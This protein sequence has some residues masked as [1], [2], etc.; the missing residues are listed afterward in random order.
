M[1]NGHVAPSIGVLLVAIAAAGWGQTPPKD[2]PA[3]SSLR[4][5]ACDDAKRAAELD[6]AIK[7]ALSADRWDEA[8][9][10]AEELAALAARALGPTHFETVDTEWRQKALRRVAPMRKD[11]R[12]LCCKRRW[13]FASAS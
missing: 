8:I 10:R 9:A 6:K 3:A 2:Q 13:T 5:L 4:K 12:A 11:D 7:A 1:F